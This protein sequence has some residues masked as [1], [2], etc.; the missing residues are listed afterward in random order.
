[1]DA[2]A[3]ANPLDLV[4][5][6]AEAFLDGRQHL[7]EQSE[8][9][10]LAV[11]VEHETGNLPDDL[12]DLHR[13]PFAQAAERSRR[14]GQQIVGTA[15]LRIDPKASDLAR[16]GLCKALQLADGIEDDL[17]AVLEHLADLVVG[18]GHAV[19]VGLAGELLAAQLELVERRGS[20]A[21]HVLLHQVEHRP[22]GKTL[23]R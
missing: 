18:P 3:E 11:V 6:V 17:V 22:G 8:V 5:Q 12:L 16:G 15:D 4:Q 21:I 13:V 2:A 14:V 19:G 10:V 7:I 20:R 1:M 23:E 9:A